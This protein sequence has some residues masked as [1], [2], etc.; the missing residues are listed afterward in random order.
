MGINVLSKRVLLG[1]VGML[2]ITA[3]SNATE[4][5][6]SSQEIDNFLA[7]NPEFLA[8]KSFSVLVKEDLTNNTR[9]YLSQNMGLLPGSSSS[10]RPVQCAGDEVERCTTVTEDGRIVEQ[11]CKCI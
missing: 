8:Q 9:I 6:L 11:S 2:A 5:A 1:L 3:T 7:N 4:L 10:L